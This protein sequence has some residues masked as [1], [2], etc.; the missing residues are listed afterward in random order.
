MAADVGALQRLPRVIGSLSLARDLCFTARKFPSAEAKDCGMVSEV[1]ET[2]EK[3]IESVFKVAELIAS[4]SPLAVQ[5]TKANMVY[6]S[7]H[8]TQE[9]L[10]QIVSSNLT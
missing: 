9:G 4:K 3:M 7:D 6:S 8:T 5:A 2:R 10:D 1:F